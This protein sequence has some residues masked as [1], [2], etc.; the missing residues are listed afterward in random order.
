MNNDHQALMHNASISPEQ[1]QYR[2]AVLSV[3][4]FLFM[5]VLAFIPGL[6]AVEGLTWGASVDF[7]RDASFVRA[8]VEG[9]Y[10]EDP[11]YLGGSLWYTPLV[12]WL[13]GLMVWLTGRPVDEVIVRMGA[14]TNLLTPI[15]FFAM[16]WY[17]LG[18]VRAVL[19]TAVFLFFIIGHEPGWATPTYSP[20][21]IPVSFCHWF[22]YI[23]LILIHRAFRNTRIGPSV[24]AG[25]GGGITF[26][27]HAGPALLSVL[28]IVLFTA[29]KMYLAVR[30]KD[31]WGWPRLRA[32][33]AAGATF[34]IFSLPLTWTVVGE[35]G[36]RTVN[37][38]YF[39]YTYY[40]LTLREKE[41]FLYHN[42][43]LFNLVALVGLWLVVRRMDDDPTGKREL[44][45]RILLTWFVLSVVLTVYSYVV[46]VLDMNFGVRLPGILPAFHFLFYAKAA[47]I[48]F[49]GV[50]LWQGFAWL[51]KRVRPMLKG[52]DLSAHLPSVVVLFGLV[53]IACTLHYP[54][55]ATR[56]DV[57]SVRNRNLAFMERTNDGEACVRIHD[58]LAWD[59]VILCEGELSIW[60]LL[61][62]ARKVVATTRTMGNPYLDQ[63]ERQGDRDLLLLAMREPRTDT[64]ALMTKYGVT[65]LLVRVTDPPTMPEIP[66]WFS[67]EVYRT[68][69]FVLFAR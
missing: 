69:E 37:R 66:K 61:A 58:L 45:R 17:F 27:A 33:L 20:R 15:A 9:H 62:S 10:G 19:C 35:Y 67:T 6:K 16:V 32:S 24:V 5:L 29:R 49:A 1:D 60:P 65:H 40:A 22:F 50:A 2:I 8:L 39:L 54:S 18:P 56:R 48:V 11:T 36:M 51:L 44:W 59:D 7:H 12:G 25:A 31:G 28:I 26:L 13:E 52:V 41:I 53:A 46:A 23:E 30:R 34:I 57:F 47:M 38:S 68:E 64:E 43:V 21:L 4:M 42:I 14:Y 3:M 55:Y 63:R